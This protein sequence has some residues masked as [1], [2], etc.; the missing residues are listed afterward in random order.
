MVVEQLEDLIK[1]VIDYNSAS[2]E[3]RPNINTGKYVLI[4]KAK[5]VHDIVLPS[6]F[7]LVC[8]GSKLNGDNIYY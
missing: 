4:H 6:S 3:S 8:K 1:V 5:K 7:N 2:K